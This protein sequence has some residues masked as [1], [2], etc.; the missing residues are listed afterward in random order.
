MVSTKIPLSRI[1]WIFLAYYSFKLL[2]IATCVIT[3]DNF[4]SVSVESYARILGYVG[5][6]GEIPAAL[7]VWLLVKH[8]YNA[9]LQ[10]DGRGNFGLT[11]V[12][13]RQMLLSILCGVTLAL[14]AVVISVMVPS[15]MTATHSSISLYLSHGTL[16]FLL[17]IST[18]VI[19]APF[20]EEL[21]F[22]GV[23]FSTMVSN[24]NVFAG[25]V[26][27]V[28]F[29][30]LVHV[31][32]LFGYWPPLMSIA[33]LGTF[34]VIVRVKMRS[35]WSSIIVHIS[36]NVLIAVLSIARFWMK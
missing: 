17:W 33:L 15:G 12:T 1:A 31:P 3:L 27:S 8:Y 35:L 2:L 13:G 21:L 9:G 30:V 22:R 19:V 5:L 32:Q 10:A 4:Y 11:R 36:Y 14:L 18:S 28:F 29:F 24:F 25:A 6:I 16:M 20:V 7:I 26:S 23:I 34:L